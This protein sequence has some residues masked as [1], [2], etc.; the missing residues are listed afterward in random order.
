MPGVKLLVLAF[1]IISIPRANQLPFQK[2]V[3]IHVNEKGEVM[4]DQA[5]YF[6]DDLAR[7]VQ[8]RLWRSYMTSGKM[9]QIILLSFDVSVSEELKK[10]V[11]YNIK[12]A[13]EKT[14]TVL[15]LHKHK[16]RF[17]NISSNKQE[18]IRKQFP[19][20]FQTDF[21]PHSTQ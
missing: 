21:S 18:K 1:L 20:L 14:L 12:T 7:E 16:K 8:Q 10:E 15:S 6:T 9:V 4:I 13:Q 2:T 3:A 11:L 17:E 5:K 19:V